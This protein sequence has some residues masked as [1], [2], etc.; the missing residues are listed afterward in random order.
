M[1]LRLVPDPPDDDTPI[2]AAQEFLVADGQT[3]A[4]WEPTDD[5]SLPGPVAAQVLDLAN[6]SL[7]DRAT[8]ARSAITLRLAGLLGLYRALAANSLRGLGRTL[9]RFGR[10]LVDVE[11]QADRTAARINGGDLEALANAHKTTIRSHL[12]QTLMGAVLIAASLYWAW[13]TIVP[14]AFATAALAAT[15][16][17][18]V[19]A[20]GWIGTDSPDILIARFLRPTGIRPKINESLI[21][22]ALQ[23]LRTPIGPALTKNPTLME[24]CWI[25]PPSIMAGRLGWETV[26]RL[27]VGSVD[28]CLLGERPMADFAAGLD[29]DVELVQIETVSGDDGG[30]AAT[31]RVVILDQPFRSRPKPRHWLLS[32][33]Q[34]RTAWTPVPIGFDLYGDTVSV[35]IVNTPC[36]LVGGIPGHGKTALLVQLALGALADPRV[37]LW[38]IDGKGD[39]DYSDI[40]DLVAHRV[41]TAPGG[42]RAGSIR[43]LEALRQLDAELERRRAAKTRFRAR[44]GQTSSMMTEAMADARI[45]LHPL[46]VVLDE[47]QSLF[48]D[49]PDKE[50]REEIK[51]IAI[52]LAKLGRSFGITVVLATQT[53][54]ESTIPRDVS[55]VAGVRIAFKTGDDVQSRQVLGREASA[56]G[57]TPERL[58]NLADRGIGYVKGD[59]LHTKLTNCL[60][61]DD[62]AGEVREACEIIRSNKDRTSWLTGDAAGETH[63]LAPTFLDHLIAAW[64]AGAAKVSHQVMAGLLAEHRPDIYRDITPEQVS[65]RGLGHGLT[66]VNNCKGLDGRWTLKGFSHQDIAQAITGGSEPPADPPAD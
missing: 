37:E 16:V 35:P 56:Q 23:N 53:I 59:G 39:S 41:V 43:A 11:G 13:Q 58:I 40:A 36:I 17:L 63:E 55:T 10:W 65:S 64:P 18:V 12:T 6:P 50:I 66:P 26:F 1:T 62:A 60:L 8:D 5:D 14:A 46:L 33:E 30:S 9:L 28:T 47:T 42:D 2:D 38:V 21:V 54:H 31:A 61:L 29:R 19:P 32:L 49:P 34:P 7:A 51:A 27:P 44:T 20:L 52:R 3:I 57:L 15:L 24:R 45:G 48:V 4:Q 25:T 22:E